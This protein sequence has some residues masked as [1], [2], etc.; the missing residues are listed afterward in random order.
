LPQR[1]QQKHT[2]DVLIVF[3]EYLLLIFHSLNMVVHFKTCS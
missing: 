2:L 3:D 1:Q